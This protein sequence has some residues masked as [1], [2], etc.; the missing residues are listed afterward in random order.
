VPR[1]SYSAVSAIWNAAYDLGMAA[2]ALGVGALVPSLG[3]PTAFLLT[4]VTMLPAFALIRTRTV[5]SPAPQPLV[6]D[7]IA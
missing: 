3:Y 6:A 1:S 4:A 7:P 5:V 2:G